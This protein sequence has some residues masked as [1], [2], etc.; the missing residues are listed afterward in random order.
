MMWSWIRGYC[1]LLCF[2]LCC[3]H[4]QGNM[5]IAKTGLTKLPPEPP[6]DALVAMYRSAAQEL[7]ERARARLVVDARK[8]TV[9]ARR[10]RVLLREVEEILA[11]LDVASAEWIAKNI[12][13]YY[14]TGVTKA[15][16]GLK[17]IGVASL[18][19]LNPVIH[20]EAVQVLVWDLQDDLLSATEGTL[21]NYRRVL[22][23]T[24]LPTQL[25]KYVT[26]EIGKGV[27]A[28]K[29]RRE[30]SRTIRDRLLSELEADT[31]KV[32]KRTFSVSNYAE[33]VARTKTS[34]AMT[35]GTINRV[36]ESGEDL[37]MV[38]AHG[39]NDGCR[40]YEGKVFSLT[41]ASD[42]Y[43][44]IKELPNGGPPFHPNCKHSLV[45]YIDELASKR[46]RK[47]SMGVPPEVLGKDYQSVEKIARAAA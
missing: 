11:E 3:T 4:W 6:I 24:Q 39:A 8:L 45:P 28:G 5:A 47:R 30:V 19:A 35:A 10:A 15:T 2:F 44:S 38:T 27:I 32:G 9:E 33:M 29:A 17:E 42:T 46:E 18:P 21:K 37:V 7:A 12:P 40:Y 36:L 25:D 41:G 23:A 22:R 14:N 13:K 34:E 16:L 31:I 20:R 1:L 43:P 26:A